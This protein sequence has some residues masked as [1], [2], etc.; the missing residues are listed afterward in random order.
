MPV[1][2]TNA[3]A[4][5]RAEMPKTKKRTARN[6]SAPARQSL[7]NSHFAG[8]APV[9]SPDSN[10]SRSAPHA[11]RD[12]LLLVLPRGPREELRVAIVTHKGERRIDARMWYESTTGEARP[13]RQGISVPPEQLT[14]IITA[15]QV[16]REKLTAT[17]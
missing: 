7:A 15:L 5:V 1:K 8:A 10:P 6:A 2:T 11:A 12:R 3:R 16:A 17:P 14:A 13:S 4:T 9:C